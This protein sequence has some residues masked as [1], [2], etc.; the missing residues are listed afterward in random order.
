MNE[1]YSTRG[2]RSG[3]LQLRLAIVLGAILGKV[4]SKEFENAGRKI[5]STLSAPKQHYRIAIK[6]EGR[7]R[8]YRFTIAGEKWTTPVPVWNTLRP[9]G[10]MY[11]TGLPSSGLLSG[12]VLPTS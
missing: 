11:S 8:S 5:F 6:I 3:I 9:D 10:G 4:R 7:V 1:P 2:N 12:V